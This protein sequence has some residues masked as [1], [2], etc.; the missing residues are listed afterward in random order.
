MKNNKIVI[1]ILSVIILQ[2]CTLYHNSSASLEEAVDKGKVKVIANYGQTFKFDKIVQKDSVYYG[3]GKNDTVQISSSDFSKIHLSDM[4]KSYDF[5]NRFF[6][7]VGI[8]PHIPLFFNSYQ[9][10]GTYNV[11]YERQ[12]NKHV[13]GRLSYGRSFKAEEHVYGTDDHS[14]AQRTFYMT[15][16]GFI[17]DNKTNSHLEVNIGYALIHEAS[18]V[19][20]PQDIYF[21]PTLPS[22]I[23]ESR[24]LHSPVLEVGYRLT[25]G[26]FIFRC[27]IGWPS[28]VYTSLGYAF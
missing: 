12:I 16:L 11:S 28:G 17:N 25:N 10:Y 1:I 13:S 8:R 18:H 21:G 6:A 19:V 3:L 4:R 24:Y 23:Q 22:Y 7:S 5:K 9:P 14:E 26:P 2:S 20:F 27:G 15:T